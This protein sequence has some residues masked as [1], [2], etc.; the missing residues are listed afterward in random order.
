MAPRHW[1]T[2]LAIVVATAAPALAQRNNDHRRGDDHAQAQQHDN[3]DQAQQAEHSRREQP[4]AQ[5]APQFE[6]T[7]QA[8]QR[9]PQIERAPQ[10]QRAPQFERAPQAVQRAPQIERAPQVQRAPQFERA[11]QAVQRAPQFE[12]RPQ[13]QQNERAIPRA[14]PQYQNRDYR[15]GYDGRYND[16]GYNDRG[17]RGYNDRGYGDRGRYTEPRRY[18][19]GA[20]RIIRPTIV[21]VLPY[22]P[23]FYRPSWS[24][25]IYYGAD[26]YYPYGYTPDGY[27]NPIPGHYYGGLRITGAPRE[28]R[29]LAD[30]YYVGIVDDFDG[31]FQHMN[32][33]AGPHHI[34][35]Q[36]DGY[37][38]VA[39]DVNIRPGE[40]ITFRADPSFF[41]PAY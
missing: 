11:P 32:L 26:G 40:T 20:P 21:Q 38:P 25:G 1:I 33:E 9:A 12:R 41:Q 19:Y 3:R 31:I 14:V 5:R 16:R 6:R 2:T 34:E 8:V 22:R 13:V 36:L 30:G 35:I 17:Y 18:G 10:V 7:P 28:A 15:P 39:F 27:F 23:Y 4:Q 24:I 37:A 29:V